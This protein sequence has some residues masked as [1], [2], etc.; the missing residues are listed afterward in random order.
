MSSAMTLDARLAQRIA[1][2]LRVHPQTRGARVTVEVQNGV[3]LLAGTVES[4]LLKQAV[5]DLARA[6]GGVRDVCNM[7]SAVHADERP[8]TLQGEPAVVG[9]AGESD[10]DDI[11]R[12]FDFI[13]ARSFARAPVPRPRFWAAV[14]AGA[15]AGWWLLV[16]LVM[17][18]GW[19]GAV[20]GCMG[21]AA[22]LRIFH[23][24]HSRR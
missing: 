8:M 22:A 4:T 11:S 23:V 12:R 7:M 18:V 24:L 5:G 13:M 17:S 6:T 15:S 21:A 2:L 20:I 9:F 1:A 19:P 14:F 3:V 10:S 16:I